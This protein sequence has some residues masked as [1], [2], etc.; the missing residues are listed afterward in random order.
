MVVRKLVKLYQA[1]TVLSF[2]IPDFTIGTELT[3]NLHNKF[4]W[5]LSKNFFVSLHITEMPMMELQKQTPCIQ[6]LNRVATY[7]GETNITHIS[8]F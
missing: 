7:F 4:I 3:Q 8:F 1:V 6:I 2:N 5:V